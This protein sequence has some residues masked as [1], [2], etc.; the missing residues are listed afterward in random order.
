MTSR[1]ELY[2]HPQADVYECLGCG[3]YLETPR[4]AVLKNGQPAVV[5]KNNQE[6]RLVWLELMEMDH[7]ACGLFKDARM[8]EEARRFRTP[9]VHRGSHRYPAPAAS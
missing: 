9:R 3:Q 6:N 2:H 4:W 8:A 7:A 1:L 5:I